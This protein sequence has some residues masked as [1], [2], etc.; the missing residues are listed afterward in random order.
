[1]KNF[2]L[3]ALEEN[4]KKRFIQFFFQ[5]VNNIATTGT[6]DDSNATYRHICFRN[7]QH[8]SFPS[9]RLREHFPDIIP[10]RGLN[11]SL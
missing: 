4:F 5:I 6:V 9:Q 10:R 3:Q 8:S 11:K 7:L 2:I 1:M